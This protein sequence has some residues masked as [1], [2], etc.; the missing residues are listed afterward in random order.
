MNCGGTRPYWI[1]LYN[2][3]KSMTSSIFF[4]L[5]PVIIIAQIQFRNNWVREIFL[6]LI[7]LLSALILRIANR[8]YA[9][10]TWLHTWNWFSFTGCSE[11]FT[12]LNTMAFLDL[13]TTCFPYQQLIKTYCISAIEF[14]YFFL[15]IIFI[16]YCNLNFAKQYVTCY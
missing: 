2:I 9:I 10:P 3:S 5:N 16:D 15:L 4:F 1:C 6:L 12:M 7:V 14:S 13:L 8:Y 11:R